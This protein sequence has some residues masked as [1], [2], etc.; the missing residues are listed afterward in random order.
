MADQKPLSTAASLRARPIIVTVPSDGDSEPV[1]ISCRR[2]DPIVLFAN[3]M[4]PLEIYA[5]VAENV[6]GTMNSFTLAAVKDPATYGDFVDR[7][8]CA[9]AVSPKVVLAE[10]DASDEAIWVEDLAPDVRVAIFM[11]TNDRLANKRVIDAV[12]EFRRNQS[13]DHDTGP[14]GAQVRDTA[15]E[16]LVGHR[17]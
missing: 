13:V 12:A 10:Q 17:P 11:K 7:W 2:P 16:S 14:D 1:R 6:S 8:V 9:A 5:N 3:D 15:V 4:L